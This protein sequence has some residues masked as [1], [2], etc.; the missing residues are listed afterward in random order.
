MLL[1]AR[2]ASA[3]DKQESFSVS[4]FAG[5]VGPLDPGNRRGVS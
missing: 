2:G 5:A 3:L 1:P 4:V